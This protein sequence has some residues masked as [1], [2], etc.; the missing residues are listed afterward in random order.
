MGW[1]QDGGFEGDAIECRRSDVDLAGI[2]DGDIGSVV[3]RDVGTPV[4]RVVTRRAVR[5][6]DACR[7]PRMR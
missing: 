1:R 7:A 4:L 5:C 6:L 3:G 2:D